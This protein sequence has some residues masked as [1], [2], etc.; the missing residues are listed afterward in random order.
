MRQ[1]QFVSQIIDIFI[2]LFQKERLNIFLKPINIITTGRGG[3]IQTIIDSVSLVK[4]RQNNP[5]IESLKHYFICKY[6]KNTT[7]YKLALNKFINSLVG[8]SL[9]CFLF[10]IKDR[11][12]ANILLDEQGNIIHIDFGFLLSHSPGNVNFE[13]AP[14]KLTSEYIDLMEGVDSKSFSY[15]KELFYNGFIALRNNYHLIM[16][17]VEVHILT[18]SDLPCFDNKEY[19]ISS[20]LSKFALDL[21]EN[22]LRKYTDS[23][24][25]TSL[26][27]WRTKAYDNFQHYCVGLN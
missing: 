17:F 5:N 7:A 24:I 27:N 10:E 13:K 19:V 9:L 2:S 16:S 18:N 20:L 1:D 26:D 11:H 25:L 14:F 3:I 23:I 21:D 6:G 12:D 8:Y 4:V 22:K 15:F